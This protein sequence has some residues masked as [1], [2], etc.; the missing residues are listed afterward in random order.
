MDLHELEDVDLDA[1][2]HIH[3]GLFNV[4]KRLVKP[5]VAAVHGDALAGR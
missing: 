2:A 4:G 1:M 3:N 5:I